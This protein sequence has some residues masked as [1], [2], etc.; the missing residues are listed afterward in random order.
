MGRGRGP[1]GCTQA[2]RKHCGGDPG[3]PDPWPRLLATSQDGGEDQ[4]WVLGYLLSISFQG[5]ETPRVLL[6]N[7]PIHLLSCQKGASS[8]GPLL[9]QTWSQGRASTQ[10]S[11]PSCS[12]VFL[13]ATG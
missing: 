2:R 6:Q 4:V 10:T 12:K 5:K 13:I 8:A 3:H 9:A 1:A 7:N 11:D